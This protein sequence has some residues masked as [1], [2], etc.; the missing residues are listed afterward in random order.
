M[1]SG[2]Y[3]RLLHLDPLP[4]ILRLL[5]ACAK[6]IGAVKPCAWL[7]HLS[8]QQKRAQVFSKSGCPHDWPTA[9]DVWYRTSINLQ[10]IRWKRFIALWVMACARSGPVKSHVWLY[11][12][13]TQ[14]KRA[15]VFSKSGGWHDRPT[16]PDVWYRTSITLQ[17]I[18]WKRFV[19]ISV[20]RRQLPSQFA[21]SRSIPVPLSMT[22]TDQVCLPL[23]RC[24][25]NSGM[26]FSLLPL[27][28]GLKTKW[29]SLDPLPEQ[30]V[31]AYFKSNRASDPNVTT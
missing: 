24:A 28:D 7:Y 19:A 9:P 10:R 29:K 20:I 21:T 2:W 23:R 26:R 14:H 30:Y 1:P 3:I 25:G 22:S 27:L 17:R 13:S 18:H 5:S 8:T 31:A 6:W 15:Q 12:L 11:R 16:A 4:Q